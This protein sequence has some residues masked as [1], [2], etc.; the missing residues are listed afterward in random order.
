MKL[1]WYLHKPPSGVCVCEIFRPH[2]SNPLLLEQEIWF[3][4]VTNPVWFGGDGCMQGRGAKFE[5]QERFGRAEKVGL[6]NMDLG[7]I[8]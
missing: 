3:E 6:E 8:L 2:I 4:S 5:G 7:I 1:I